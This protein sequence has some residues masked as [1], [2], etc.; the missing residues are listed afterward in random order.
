VE[1]ELRFAIEPWHVLVDDAASGAAA[2]YV[3]SSTERMQISVSGF[4]PARHLLACNGSPVPLMSAGPPGHYVAGIRYK[5][6]KPWSS[7]HPTLEVDAPLRIEV[8]DRAARISLGGATYHVS[9]PGGR[10]YDKPPVNAQEAEARRRARFEG[11]GHTPGMIDVEAL[12]SQLAW[13]AIPGADYAH[14]LDLRHRVPRRW[15]RS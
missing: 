14:T 8:I 5:A 4:D 7:L 1:L 9:H 10:S 6:W 2:R 13:R 15:G 11:F 3:D 12:D